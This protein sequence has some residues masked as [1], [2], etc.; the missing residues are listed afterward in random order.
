MFILLCPC[1]ILYLQLCS[2]F[3]KDLFSCKILDRVHLKATSGVNKDNT[4]LT[5]PYLYI[6]KLPLWAVC[7]SFLNN[8]NVFF[9]ALVMSKICSMS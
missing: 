8:H 9:K 4:G 5:K 2:Y 6:Q 3:C 1:K 7:A